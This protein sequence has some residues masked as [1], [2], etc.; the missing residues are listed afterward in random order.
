M[1]T[2]I[3]DLFQK[4]D[5]QFTTVRK[6][7]AWLSF[8]LT[9]IILGIYFFFTL[10]SLSPQ[11]PGLYSFLL[12]GLAIFTVLRLFFGPK[13]TAGAFKR[14]LL[15]AVIL[16]V[17]PSLLLFFSSPVFRAGSFAKLIQVEPGVF[18]EDIEKIT[19]SQVPV[20][21][22]ETASIIGEKQLGS[23][24]DLVS[25]FVIDEQ[26]S[27]VN[28]SGKPFRISP[29]RY[30]DIIKY[31]TN[32]K[33]GI[34]YYVSVDMTS[35]EGKV[36]KLPKAVYYSPGDYLMRNIYRKIRFQY[37]FSIL[38]ESNFEIDDEGNAYYITPIL[39]KTIGFLNGTD[40][41]SVII[42][43]AN[44][45]KST[46]YPLDQVPTWVDRVYP[47]DLIISQL[48]NR[49][50]YTGG[51]FNSVFGQKNVT[52]TTEGYNYISIGEDIFLTTGV[53]SVRSD[54]SNLGFYYANLR[55]KETKF[56][57]L[58][59]ATETAAMSSARGKVQEKEY[60]PTFP[61]LLNIQDRPVYFM[62]LKD[63]AK[64]AKMYAFVDAQQFTNV[65]VADDVA[66]LFTAYA[67]VHPTRGVTSEEYETITIDTLK[68]VTLDGN[69]V[70]FITIK[71]N[72]KIYYA[73]ASTLQE[74]V[75]Q[76]KEGAR[77]RVLSFEQ[78]GVQMIESLEN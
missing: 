35:Q 33:D 8:L 7:K 23:L 73:T 59:S 34:Q 32:R 47:A 40:V 36:V 16:L 44:S 15:L 42:T 19:R 26:Y 62:S 53:T 12:M 17:L 69:T 56:Y 68:E 28:I 11:S 25:Q 50:L 14:S 48:D 74:K 39:H 58:A 31:I 30:Y 51:F 61:V 9:I 29:L 37:P 49:G 21:D 18:E 46:T 6:S 24:T 64:T 22:R 1:K 65:V 63:Q 13:L 77:L 20:V 54:E 60:Q 71:E 2:K 27:Q 5:Q 45:G 52:S 55:T 66:S 3:N 4:I 43:D 70:F 72:D 75:L 76:M 41:K 78:G 10:P 38:G 67:K 57:S